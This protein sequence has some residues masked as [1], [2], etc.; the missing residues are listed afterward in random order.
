MIA[1]PKMTRIHVHAS[2]PENQEQRQEFSLTRGLIKIE[3]DLALNP[4]L[5]MLFLDLEIIIFFKQH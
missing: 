2:T 3:S 1:K 4:L 5:H